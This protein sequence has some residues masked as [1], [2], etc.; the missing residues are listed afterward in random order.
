MAL[1]IIKN[2]TG[3]PSKYDGLLIDTS[4]KATSLCKE[5]IATN[6]RLSCPD[7]ITVIVTTPFIFRHF[8][9]FLEHPAVTMGTEQ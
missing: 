2:Y 6:L 8:G 7:R 3:N 1:H 5:H 9:A 4:I